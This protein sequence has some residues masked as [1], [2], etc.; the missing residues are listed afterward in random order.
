MFTFSLTS[1][2]RI[3]LSIFG[4][5]VQKQLEFLDSNKDGFL[6]HEDVEVDD[7]MI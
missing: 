2:R 5:K 4:S 6:D 3:P 1:S 7:R